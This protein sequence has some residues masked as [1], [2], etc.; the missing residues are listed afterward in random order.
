MSVKEVLRKLKKAFM[1]NNEAL[2]S[3]N[4]V[5]YLVMQ[6]IIFWDAGESLLL[7]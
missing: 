1:N 6:Y 2:I 7:T 5:I 4:G 3:L